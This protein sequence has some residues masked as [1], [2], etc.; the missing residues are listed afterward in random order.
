MAKV[1]ITLEDREDGQTSFH[2][3][4]DTDWGE[5]G[6]QTQA[7]I[8]GFVFA[9]RVYNDLGGKELTVERRG[10]EKSGIS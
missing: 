3:T 10:V 6:T 4:S 1:V 5:T 9:E 2:L 8:L 7:Q